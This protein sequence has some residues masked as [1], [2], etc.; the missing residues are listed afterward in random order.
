MAQDNGGWKAHHEQNSCPLL[1]L[2]LETNSM[3][4]LDLHQAHTTFFTSQSSKRLVISTSISSSATAN[5]VEGSD[6]VKHSRKGQGS[7]S[8]PSALAQGLL[9]QLPE[10]VSS[11]INFFPAPLASFGQC[12]RPDA[13]LHYLRLLFSRSLHS[14]PC[15][16]SQPRVS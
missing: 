11:M 16:L 1:L 2:Q 13:F 7:A 5:S 12:F 4:S 8:S 14:L 6:S 10:V 15:S 9:Q 3:T